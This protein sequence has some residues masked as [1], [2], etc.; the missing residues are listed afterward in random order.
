MVF[1]A[2]FDPLLLGNDEQPPTWIPSRMAG[3][4]IGFFFFWAVTA[5]AAV[6]TAYLLDTLPAEAPTVLNTKQNNGATQGNQQARRT[7]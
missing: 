2:F 6:L 7:P 4:A 5:G 3:Y 1:F